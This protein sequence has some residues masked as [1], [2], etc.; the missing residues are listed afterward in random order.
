MITSYS[1]YDDADAAYDEL[2]REMNTLF[3]GTSDSIMPLIKEIVGG[4]DIAEN[5]LQAHLSF[6]AQLVRAESQA[7]SQGQ[8]SQLDLGDNLGEIVESRMS[9]AARKWWKDDL[10]RRKAGMPRQRLQDL[11]NLLRTNI[12]ILG[13]RKSVTAALGASATSAAST[14]TTRNVSRI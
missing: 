7:T 6:Y 10:E 4:D 2:L 14:S 13:A 3:A 8:M 12:V 9:Y 5:D 11:K 1:A